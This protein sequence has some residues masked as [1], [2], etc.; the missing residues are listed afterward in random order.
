MS[1]NKFTSSG[2]VARYTAVVMLIGMYVTVG[3]FYAS[4]SSA[5]RRQSDVTSDVQVMFENKLSEHLRRTKADVKTF[6]YQRDV[7]IELPSI[8]IQK[9]QP[10]LASNMNF[11]D[12]ISINSKSRTV[13][14][15]EDNLRSLLQQSSSCD[16]LST[17]L[18]NVTYLTS[19]WTKDVY[20]ALLNGRPVAVKLAADDGHDIR[21][22]QQQQLQPA[23]SSSH[24]ICLAAAERKLLKEI[25]LLNGLR[26]E[27][28]IEVSIRVI[29]TEK[30]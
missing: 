29:E 14:V 1:R 24:D 20:T 8:A 12:T 9:L 28:V 5:A 11:H 15:T 6:S 7:L 3:M 25:A 23:S 19:G 30:N 26:H 10:S 2:N 16:M 17:A 22:C 13:H 4:H 18:T 27:N 21:R